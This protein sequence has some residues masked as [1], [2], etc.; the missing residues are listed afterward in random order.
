LRTGDWEGLG[1]L[2]D[3]SHDS[4]R[5]DYEVSCE[6]LDIAVDAAR[7]SGALGARMTGGGFGGSA[8]ALVPSGDVVSVRAAVI[9]AFERLG[10]RTPDVF[11]VSASDGARRDATDQ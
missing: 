10:W 11:A 6:E 8:V 1:R 5:D 2:M 4:L 3:A 7:D 9:A